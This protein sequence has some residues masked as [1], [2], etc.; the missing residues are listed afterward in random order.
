MP[1]ACSMHERTLSHS[2]YLCV[3]MAECGSGVYL[4]QIAE[5]MKQ[6]RIQLR[7]EF[8]PS[9]SRAGK[10]TVGCKTTSAVKN[11]L[12]AQGKFMEKCVN[13]VIRFICN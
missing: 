13:V 4:Y 6:S 3:N 8:D 11:A 12:S 9:Q 7:W 1:C 2:S 5:K 10:C